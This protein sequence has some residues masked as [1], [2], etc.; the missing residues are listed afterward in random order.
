M[1]RPGARVKRPVTTSAKGEN[2]DHG[3]AMANDVMLPRAQNRERHDRQRKQ[4]QEMNGA[5]GAVFL[6][7]V[8]KRLTPPL[9]LKVR[10][11][12]GT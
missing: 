11:K 9:G 1:I 10:Q 3:L 7:H 4:R 8:L 6:G 2:P 12:S 5:P